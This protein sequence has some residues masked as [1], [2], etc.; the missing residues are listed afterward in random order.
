[1]VYL[2]RKSFEAAFGVRQLM[3]PPKPDLVKRLEKNLPL[4]PYNRKT[5]Y[6]PESSEGYIDYPFIEESKL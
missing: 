1:V 2:E 4:N 3:I 5:F 6:I